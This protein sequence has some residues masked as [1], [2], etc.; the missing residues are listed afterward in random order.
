MTVPGAARVQRRGRPRNAEAVEKRQAILTAATT[1]FLT[2]GYRD[3]SMREVAKAADVSTRTLYN[4]Y[5]DKAS[6]FGACLSA[7]SSDSAEPVL[8]EELSV[9]RTLEHFATNMVRQ[10]SRPDSLGFARLVM[11]DGKD[12]PELAEA[13]YASQEERFVQPLAAYLQRAGFA[14]DLVQPLATLFIA[15]AISEWNRAVTFHLRLPDQTE[16]AGHA[17]RAAAIFIHGVAINSKVAPP[18]AV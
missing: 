18:A 3:V 16:I 6:L 5:V 13:G 9:E 8:V 14:Q 4:L 7:L 10:L 11:N 1:L 15:M 12:F 17:R 2:S